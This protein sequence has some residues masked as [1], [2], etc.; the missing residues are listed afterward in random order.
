[1]QGADHARAIEEAFH[2]DEQLS[3]EGGDSVE[4]HVSLNC[5]QFSMSQFIVPN[6]LCRTLR[7]LPGRSCA[8]AATSRRVPSQQLVC[9]RQMCPLS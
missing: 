2:R 7:S 5:F 8:R 1:M 4:G 3:S 9:D 6:R